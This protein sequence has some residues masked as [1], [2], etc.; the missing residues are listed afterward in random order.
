M[1]LIVELEPTRALGLCIVSQLDNNS[2]CN[3][4]V[5]S[6]WQPKVERESRGLTGWP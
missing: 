5:K 1:V 4:V 2:C 3:C 6:V